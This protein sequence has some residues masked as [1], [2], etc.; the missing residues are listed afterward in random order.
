MK[1]SKPTNSSVNSPHQLR[2]LQRQVGGAIMTSLT[3]RWGMQKTSRR[4]ADAF[5]KRNDRLTSFERLEIYNRQYWFRLIDC[6]YDDYPGL[7]AVVG[8][9]KFSKLTR[10]YL[11]KYPSTSFTLRNLGRHLERFLH[12]NPHG[13]MAL[14]MA[15]LEWA[16]VV[17]FDGEAR[18][19]VSVDD[20]LGA[21]P[22]KLRLHLQPYLSLL[23]LRYPLDDY[24]IALKK[25]NVESLRGEASNA[26]TQHIH[27]R[28]KKLRRPR[29]ETV[30]VA[31]HRMEN[32]V[33]YKRLTREQFDL[34]RALQ[35]GKT[36]QQACARAS[37][38]KVGDIQGWFGAWASFG[39]FC[40]S[41]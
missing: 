25:L 8:N 14:D 12:K 28:V 41:C 30:H 6:F 40:R 31:V 17:A 33:Y 21:N 38:A 27:K 20:L 32:A 16:R 34:L 4:I 29:A 1:R 19:V 13:Q 3:P 18:P 37:A 26:V 9:R 36:L 35:S 39:W 2:E 15:R 11:A 10:A 5:I 24:L 7:H 23:E 22:A